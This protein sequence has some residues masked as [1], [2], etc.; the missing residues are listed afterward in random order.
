MRSR[1]PVNLPD[2]DGWMYLRCKNQGTRWTRC[3]TCDNTEHD[4]VVWICDGKHS[5]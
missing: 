5:Y 4:E 2:N 3:S 1:A